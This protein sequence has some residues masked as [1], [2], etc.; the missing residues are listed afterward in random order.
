LI[1]NQIKVTK[2]EEERYAI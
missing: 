1:D 2:S